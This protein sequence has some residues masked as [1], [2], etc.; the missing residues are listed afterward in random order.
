MHVILKII[1]N[2]KLVVILESAQTCA[3]FH[4]ETVELSFHSNVTVCAMILVF[5][6]EQHYCYQNMSLTFLPSRCLIILYHLQPTGSTSR[7]TSV[8]GNSVRLLS[9]SAS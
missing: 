1:N 6:M 7:Q 4:T 8:S 2:R 5:R 9:H 3:V